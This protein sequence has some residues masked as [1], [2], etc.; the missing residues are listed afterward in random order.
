MTVRST[1]L[2]FPLRPEYLNLPTL[3]RIRMSARHS[4]LCRESCRS[5]SMP[6][7]STARLCTLSF[8][9]LTRQT[10]RS[11]EPPPPRRWVAAINIHAC[12][13]CLP[14]GHV[15]LS[16]PMCVYVLSRRV[17][18]YHRQMESKKRERERKRRE[19][20]GCMPEERA[21]LLPVM[22]ASPVVEND[23]GAPWKRTCIRFRVYKYVHTRACTDNA[24]FRE[25]KEREREVDRRITYKY[26]H[27]I[28]SSAEGCMTDA[29]CDR[30]KRERISRQVSPD[31]WKTKTKINHPPRRSSP[32]SCRRAIR[33]A[34]SSSDARYTARKK[35]T[36]RKT[37]I[38]YL[39]VMLI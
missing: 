32:R 23:D 10:P 20:E 11:S 38:L 9:V 6:A 17:Y 18:V 34:I 25:R 14:P 22:V 5:T 12:G 29:I 28:I 1:E 3:V 4:R 16:L 15:H 31:P 37:L 30:C 36:D 24:S 26:M 19:R 7:T 8:V 2:S 39:I 35:R 21:I 33:P 27:C 13:S